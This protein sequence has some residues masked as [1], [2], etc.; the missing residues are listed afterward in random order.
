[1]YASKLGEQAIACQ[2]QSSLATEDT[3][4]ASCVCKLRMPDLEAIISLRKCRN[5]RP[6]IDREM[7]KERNVVERYT[8]RLKENRRVATRCDRKAGRFTLYGVGL[9]FA[10]DCNPKAA[11]HWFEA[12]K[13]KMSPPQDGQ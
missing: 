10:T 13:A 4:T 9:K 1:M 8:G 7:Y 11:R 12:A 5:I 2:A 3:L 6:A